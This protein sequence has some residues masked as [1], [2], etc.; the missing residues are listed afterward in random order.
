MCDGILTD[1]DRIGGIQDKADRSLES[2]YL[3]DYPIDNFDSALD[4]RGETLV[5]PL[6]EAAHTH[7][8]CLNS[9][10]EELQLWLERVDLDPDTNALPVH[11]FPQPLRG[12]DGLTESSWSDDVGHLIT[13]AL[14]SIK[15]CSSRREVRHHPGWCDPMLWIK[16]PWR[17]PR[18]FHLVEG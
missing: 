2:G 11:S 8:E 17:H 13:G 10:G 18:I 7:P 4:V 6:C 15:E 12:K 5:E 3:F 14:Q 1:T 16:I 9:S